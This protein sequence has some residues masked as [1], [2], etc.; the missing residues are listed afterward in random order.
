MQWKGITPG[1]V[2]VSTATVAALTQIYLIVDAWWA[3]A[4]RLIP[5]PG[6]QKFILVISILTLCAVG[7]KNS[8]PATPT[9]KPEK[10]DQSVG[11]NA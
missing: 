11:D 7:I 2:I 3:G 10:P 4:G 8:F 1:F 9:E 6:I 5:P